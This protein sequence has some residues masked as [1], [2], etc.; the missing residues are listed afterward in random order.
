MT[1]GKRWEEVPP[2]CLSLAPGCEVACEGVPGQ[3]VKEG[4]HSEEDEL[5]LLQALG[6]ERVVYYHTKNHHWLLSHTLPRLAFL[7]HLHVGT[8]DYVWSTN[9]YPCVYDQVTHNVSQTLA[10]CSC[11]ETAAFEVHRVR[12]LADADQGRHIRVPPTCAA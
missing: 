4:T 2:L 12:C 1:F 11:L 8:A 5:A 6:C 3:P 10:L 9:D 7:R